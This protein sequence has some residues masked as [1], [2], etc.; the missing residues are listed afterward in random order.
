[1]KDQIAKACGGLVLC[2]VPLCM[3]G[4]FVG[5]IWAFFALVALCFYSLG[6][7]WGYVEKQEKS[8]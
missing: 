3:L 5:W 2:L 4:V 6:A 7:M 1:M 8:K